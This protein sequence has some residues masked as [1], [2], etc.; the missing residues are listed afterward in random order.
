MST[1]GASSPARMRRVA[2]T[3]SIRGI[4]TSITTTSGRVCADD[5]DGL[6]AVAGLADHLDVR[7]AAEYQPEPGPDQ[8]LIVHQDDADHAH[9]SQARTRN[10]PA[11]RVPR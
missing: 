9:G 7:L 11:G 4:R 6:R 8:F 1:R 3:P 2:S 5:L 10:P